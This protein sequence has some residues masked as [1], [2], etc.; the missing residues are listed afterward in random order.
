M[1]AFSDCLDKGVEIA[2]SEE[3]LRGVVAYN[4]YVLG[5]QPPAPQTAAS[6]QP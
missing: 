1:P 6:K 3:V 2:F 4:F 5:H